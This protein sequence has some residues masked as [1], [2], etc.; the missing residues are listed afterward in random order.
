MDV[1]TPTYRPVESEQQL[2]REER[3]INR[4]AWFGGAAVS[5]V[6]FTLLAFLLITATEPWQYFAYI[7]LGGVPF[8]YAAFCNFVIRK[9]ELRVI[10]Q[11][12]TQLIIRLSELEEMASH[13][14]LTGLHNRRYF[15]DALHVETNRAH[16]S[17]DPLAV[18]L[19]D[20]DG[21]K[22]LNDEYGHAVGDVILGNLARVIGKHI[23]STDVAAR[24]GGD[25]FGVLMPAADKRGAF[26]MAR[27]LWD[28]LEHSPMYE[29]GP[30]RVMV[31]ISIG[32]AGF[33]WGGETVEEMIQWA[34]ADMYANKVSRRLPREAV[35]VERG[36]LDSLPEDHVVGI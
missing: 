6:T 18:I 8:A 27:R 16:Q 17:K 30:L 10:H 7:F 1:E 26:A 22:L 14:G 35:G 25:E 3:E 9:M 28:E 33:P 15:Y 13:D 36:E 2:A 19:M 20:L 12:Q 11:Y 34:D 4:I 5:L 24:V 31:T 23:R 29:D 21:L 32:V